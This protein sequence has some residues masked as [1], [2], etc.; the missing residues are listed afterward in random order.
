MLALRARGS[1][2]QS[3][4]PHVYVSCSWRDGEVHPRDAV[5]SEMKAQG[6]FLVGDALDQRDFKEQGIARITR[7][8]SGCS[9]FVGLYPDRQ[10]PQKA[11]EELYK[12]FLDE[13][14]IANELGVGDNTLL[15]RM[16]SLLLPFASNRSLSGRKG[17]LMQAW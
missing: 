6:A 17:N 3:F 2:P 5:L 7:I 14:R 13:L 15:R 4:Q 1:L 8:M 10:S 11:P 16:D 9:G 12:Y